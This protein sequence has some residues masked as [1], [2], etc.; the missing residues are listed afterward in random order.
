MSNV[1]PLKVMQ[2]PDRNEN[3][4]R[5]KIIRQVAMHRGLCDG[6]KGDSYLTGNEYRS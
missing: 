1:G 4:R 6:R 2:M 3:P 5:S